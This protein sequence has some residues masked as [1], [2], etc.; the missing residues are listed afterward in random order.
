MPFTPVHMGPGIF[1]KALF[2]GSFSLMIFGWTQIVVDLQP[3]YVLFKGEGHLHGFSHTYLGATLLAVVAAMTGKWLSEF[4]LWR[5]G[6]NLGRRLKLSW[7]VVFFSAF[8]GSYSHVFL[9]SIM[10]ADVRPFF[11]VSEQNPFLQFISTGMLHIVSL[12]FG[13]VG[14]VLYFIHLKHQKKQY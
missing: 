13:M 12:V 9:D 7:I 10:H 2:G 5:M 6:L 11:P 14:A 8:I 3:L 4:F 1:L